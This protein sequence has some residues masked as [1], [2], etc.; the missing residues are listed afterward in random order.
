MLFAGLLLLSANTRPDRLTCMCH[1][2]GAT[3]HPQPKC[4]EWKESGECTKNENYMTEN[5]RKT[6]DKCNKIE[7]FF[8]ETTT[9]ASCTGFSHLPYQ[10]FASSARPTLYVCRLRVCSSVR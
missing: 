1:V 6:C 3:W 10:G 2:R 4:E 8:P 7:K 9:K 5:C